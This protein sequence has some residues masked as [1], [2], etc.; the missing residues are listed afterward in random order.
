MSSKVEIGELDIELISPNTSNFN[1][2]GSFGRKIVI[3]GK[4]GC[5]APGTRVLMYDQSVKT[6]EKIQEGEQLMGDDGTPRN[7]L[8]LCHN[9][10]NMYKIRGKFGNKYTVNE[11]HIL[12]LMDDEGI[13]TELTVADYLQRDKDWQDRQYIF[14]SAIHYDNEEKLQEYRHFFALTPD[15]TSPNFPEQCQHY[16]N[17]LEVAEEDAF[18]ARSLGFECTVAKSSVANYSISTYFGKRSRWIKSKFCVEQAEYGEYYGFVL[19]GNHRFLLPSLDVMHNTGKSSLIC[20]IMY[21]KRHIFPVGFAMSG[22]EDVNHTFS[23]IMPRLFVFNDYDETKVQD[24]IRR[25]KIAKSHLP[26]PWCLMIIDDC[27]DD[28]RIFRKPLQQG[29]FKKSR[30]WSTLYL[31]SLQYCMDVLPSIRTN[32]DGVF[33][34]RETNRKNR[35]SLYEN[36]AGVIPSFELFCSLMDQLTDD[37]TAMYIHNAT[38]TA[39]WRECVYWYK[40]DPVPDGFRFGC[41]EYWDFAEQRYNEDYQDPLI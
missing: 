27:T 18:K 26:N 29:I 7:V 10:D 20:D 13:V 31:L 39:D 9:F 38:Q 4:P 16:T 22:S 24:F 35:K 8:E 30:H 36:Y 25:Q 2:P 19:D 14:Q 3:I 12:V 15:D 11:Q 5:L 33:I 1:K 23:Q 32:V 40:A 41:Q 28:P 17:H 21:K 6:V 34:L 37:F